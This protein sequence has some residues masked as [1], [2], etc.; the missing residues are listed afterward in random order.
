LPAVADIAIVLVTSGV[1]SGTPHGNPA[2][3]VPVASC[4]RK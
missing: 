1:G 3:L 2:Q 4:T